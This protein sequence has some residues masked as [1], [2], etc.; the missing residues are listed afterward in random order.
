MSSCCCQMTMFHIS[1]DHHWLWVGIPKILGESHIFGS[2]FASPNWA[3]QI[4]GPLPHWSWAL[5]MPSPQSVWKWNR[6]RYV[7]IQ[8]GKLTDEPMDSRLPCSQRNPSQKVWVWTW[9]TLLQIPSP[10]IW[11]TTA[12]ETLAKREKQGVSF[13]SL[14]CF[15]GTVR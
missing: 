6:S 11:S 1:F 9:E 4:L 3:D 14:V 13:I 2:N 5:K 10:K 12:S 7:Q 15:K 8:W